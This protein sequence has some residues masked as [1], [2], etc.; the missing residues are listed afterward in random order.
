MYTYTVHNLQYKRLINYVVRIG[1][2][3]QPIRQMYCENYTFNQISP[4]VDN[5]RTHV[6][7]YAK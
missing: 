4:N 2:K 5:Q 3:F 7:E 6:H 1:T